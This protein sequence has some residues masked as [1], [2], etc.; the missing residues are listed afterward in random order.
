M[1]KAASDMT[2]MDIRKY[3]V[4]RTYLLTT[5]SRDTY[6]NYKDINASKFQEEIG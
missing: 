5:N 6:Y 1:I 3:Q 4:L 2:L